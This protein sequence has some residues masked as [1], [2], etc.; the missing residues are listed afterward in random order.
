MPDV[1]IDRFNV[2]ERLLYTI[3]RLITLPNLHIYLPF[4]I[5]C[6]SSLRCVINILRQWKRF[7]L[8]SR[9]K[10]RKFY[11]LY[12]LLKKSVHLHNMHRSTN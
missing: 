6:I 12:H 10:L 4:S 2:K 1:S 7:D 8:M 11:L 3:D 9:K 5:E